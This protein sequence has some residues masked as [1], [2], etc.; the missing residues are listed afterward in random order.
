MGARDEILAANDRYAAAFDRAGLAAP[1]TRAFA[2]LTC[3]D[4]RLD[5]ALFLGLA[6]GDAHVLRNAGGFA[7]D[8]ALR[9]LAISAHLLGTREA[10]VIAHEQCGMLSFANEELRERIGPAARDVDFLPFADL[11]EAVR[12]SVR[13]IRGSELLPAG[14]GATGFVYDVESGRLREIA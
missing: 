7:T 9:S 12:E 8:D 2:I 11:D 6:G 10:F 1:P 13:R 4:A 5:P 14:F 3:M